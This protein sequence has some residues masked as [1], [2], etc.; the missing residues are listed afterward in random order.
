MLGRPILMFALSILMNS[1]LG[2]FCCCFVLFF[3]GFCL[4]TA[5][6]GVERK[7]RIRIIGCTKCCCQFRLAWLNTVTI[8][9][10]RAESEAP[11]KLRGVE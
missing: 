2:F 10:K 4:Y 1:F 3:V 8:A 7:C 9:F 6:R 11:P 5:A